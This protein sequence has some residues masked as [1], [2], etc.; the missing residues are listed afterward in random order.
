MKRPAN[1]LRYRLLTRCDVPLDPVHG[2]VYVSMIHRIKDSVVIA[3]SLLDSLLSREVEQRDRSC[4]I[5]QA[6]DHFVQILMAAQPG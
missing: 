2:F 1:K 5:S 4:T 6:V 3:P